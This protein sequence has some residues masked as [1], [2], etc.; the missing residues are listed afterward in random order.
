M[1]RSIRSLA[2]IAAVLLAVTA[3]AD[4]PAAPDYAEVQPTEDLTLSSETAELRRGSQTIVEIALGDTAFSTLVAAVVEAGLVDAL[5]GNDQLTVFAP[6][7]AAFAKLGLNANNVAS[8]GKDALTDILLY[9]VTEGRR[10]AISLLFTRR[11]K[12]LNG[13]RTQ[14]RLTRQ[15]LFVNQS[16]VVAAN[17]SASNGVVHVIDSVLLPPQD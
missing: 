2:V 17:I 6:T 13:D 15:G 4:A 10:G 11:L 7:N 3:C 16:K 14:V 1:L 5:N 9:H 8:L 12:M